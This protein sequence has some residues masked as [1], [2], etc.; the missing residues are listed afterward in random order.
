MEIFAETERL[1]LREIVSTDRNGL[2]KIDSDPDVN[3]YLGRKPVE[4]IEQIDD[5]IQFIRNQYIENGIGRWA[6][7]EKS[8]TNFIGWT[9]LKFVKETTNNHCNYY[10]L[11]YRLNKKYWGKGLATEAAKASLNYGFNDLNLNEIYAM[12]DSKNSASRN[13]IEKVGLKHI[14]TFEFNETPYDWFKITKPY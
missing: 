10:D 7:I 2:F 14:E 5:I 6:M 9:G 13:V 12:A 11:G 4:N 1:I 8:T 3:T